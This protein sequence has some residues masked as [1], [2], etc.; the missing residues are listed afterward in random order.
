MLARM[1]GF[2]SLALGFALSGCGGSSG[3]GTP[4]V[5]PPP[6]PTV[7]SLGTSGLRGT[8]KWAARAAR[9]DP[10]PGSVA[11]SSNIDS[12][13]ATADRIDVEFNNDI[14]RLT[15][16]AGEG[17]EIGTGNAEPWDEG[18]ENAIGFVRQEDDGRR[19][20]IAY[21]IAPE[22]GGTDW[23]AAGIWA[24]VPNSEQSDD[25]EF[26]AFADGVSFL[27]ENLQALTGDATYTGE[28]VGVYYSQLP[29][30][31]EASPFGADVNLTASFG[32]AN[33]LGSI[34][35][36]ISGVE[37]ESGSPLGA[38]LTLGT[39]LIGDSDSGF[40]TGNTSMTF[41]GRSYGGRWG[42]QFFGSSATDTPSFVAGTFGATTGEGGAT[43]SL[44]GA[45]GAER[46]AQ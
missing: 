44:V 4:A 10:S 45:F 40:F 16:V 30:D 31:G 18:P 14:F 37:T 13:G 46:V 25:Y 26:G 42:G 38:T 27:G 22:G 7:S 29:N 2:A 24:F 1:M 33:V 8:A 41:G 15:Q 5:S 11:Q 12:T 32:D 43:G 36:T 21:T 9:S 6:T 39:A 34:S 19:F 28:A 23:L 20:L 35:G 3:A 17:W